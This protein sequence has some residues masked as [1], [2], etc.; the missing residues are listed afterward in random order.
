MTT[1]PV[2]DGRIDRLVPVN[3]KEDHEPLHLGRV[4]DGGAANDSLPA[5]RGAF[6]LFTGDL[7]SVGDQLLPQH[8]PQQ[9]CVVPAFSGDQLFYWEANCQQTLDQP[10]DL[11]S[12]DGAVL[13]GEKW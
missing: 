5:L 3:P 6:S 4:E 2:E 11:T 7:W 10:W 8:L 9:L 1:S 12:F 13:F